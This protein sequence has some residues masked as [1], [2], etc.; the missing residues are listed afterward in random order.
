M[1][2]RKEGDPFP[3][4]QAV[5]QIP[6]GSGRGGGDAEHQGGQVREPSPEL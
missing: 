1:K 3:R 4:L 6:T 2:H 5:L